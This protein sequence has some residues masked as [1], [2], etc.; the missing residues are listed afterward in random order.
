V[1]LSDVMSATGLSSWAELGLILCFIT[2]AAI[3]FWVFVI[4]RRR[5]YEHARGLPL[6]NGASPDDH[7]GTGKERL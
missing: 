5:S 6:D 3:V 2:F 7:G 4:R 1:S